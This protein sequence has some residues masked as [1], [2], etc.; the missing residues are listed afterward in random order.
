VTEEKSNIDA[1]LSL[2]KHQGIIDRYNDLRGY[3]DMFWK[4]V[5]GKFPMALACGS[6]CSTCCELQSVNFLEA[7]VI[8]RYCADNKVAPIRS[9]RPQSTCPF[10]TD[11]R[12]RIYPVR[13]LICRT[14]GLLLKS[15]DF[16][17]RIAVSCPFNFT[18][19]DYA[20]VA[21]RDALDVD[22]VTAGLA[23]LNAA[24][25]LLH[26]DIKKASERIALVDLAN[27]NIGPSWFNT[28]TAQA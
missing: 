18:S 16:K 22:T 21:D 23:K 7:S 25:C 3:C 26:G 12:C 17:D 27:K 5:S 24:F 8:A 1:V 14:H 11:G 2:S 15:K 10:L 20:A 19:M 28:G 9:S 6:G 4:Q 13:P